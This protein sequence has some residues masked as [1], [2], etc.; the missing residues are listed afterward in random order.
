[1][2]DTTGGS[3]SIV[4]WSVRDLFRLQHIQ[5]QHRIQESSIAEDDK[6]IGGNRRKGDKHPV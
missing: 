6:T 4:N 3:L 1:M 2:P 5:Q